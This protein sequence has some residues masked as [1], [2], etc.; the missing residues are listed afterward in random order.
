MKK[1]ITLLLSVLLIIGTLP[2]LPGYAAEST[3]ENLALGKP[4]TATSSMGGY[5]PSNV[6]DGNPGT[7]W[8]GNGWVTVDL[9]ETYRITSVV[10]YPRTDMDQVQ[11]R[12]NL[13]LELSKT[14][15]FAEQERM[16]AVDN[17]D[18]G[19]GVPI[20]VSI[21]SKTPYR[22]VR[23]GQKS[24]GH[25][26]IAEIEIFGY[27]L[28]PNALEIGED[29]SGHKHE[30]PLTLLAY[31]GLLENV[32]DNIFGV[33]HLLTRGQAARAVVKALGGNASFSGYLPFTD[34]PI[35]HKNYQDI[36]TAYHLGIVTGSDGET[37]R[38]NE[39]VSKTELLF[40]TLRAIGYDDVIPKL[41]N[42]SVSHVLNLANKLDLLKGVEYETLDEPINRADAHR[43]FYNALLAP[44][45][46]MYAMQE[47]HLVFEEDADLLRRRHNLV[48]TQGVVEETRLTNLDGDTKQG[49]HAVR[50]SGKAFTDPNGMLDAYIGRNV[51]VAT[52]QDDPERILL[53]LLTGRDE[54]VVLPA[55]RL[56]STEADINSGHI[57]ALDADGDDER[58]TL[59]DTF[60]VIKNGVV[61]PYYTT[62]DLML[63]NG[64]M[65]LLDNNR[66]GMY[67]VVFLEEYTVHYV[68][69][70]FSDE[71]ELTIVN[72]EG[73][74]FLLE[75]ESLSVTN[76]EGGT[77]SVKTITR[78]T[79]IKL[80]STPDG[81][82]CRIVLYNTP[83][84]GKLTAISDEEAAIDGT[85]YPLS[86]FYK[87]KTW[88]FEPRP[89]E[90]VK[91]FVDEAG[92]ILW[93][94]RGSEGWTIAFS[95]KTAIGTG[96]S[97]AVI[98]RMFTQDGTWKEHDVAEK[99]TL[100]GV[101]VTRED[102]A[103]KIV[104]ARGT[105]RF[106]LSMLRYKL[107][108]A[109]QIKVL[110][111]L[112]ETAAESAD[113]ISFN[114]DR[115]IGTALYTSAS[116]SF[117]SYQDQIYFAKSDTPTFVL[118][119]VNGAYTADSSY[120]SLY[121]VRTVA[122][123]AGQND[124]HSLGLQAYMLDEDGYPA[125][126]V[127]TDI[128][129]SG[130]G[131]T[132]AVISSNTAPNLLVEKVVR[133]VVD[134]TVVIKV[135]GYNVLNQTEASFY[136]EST[137]DMIETGL[138]FQEKPN[139][140]KNG[141]H[142]H[143][144]NASTLS[145]LTDEEKAIYISSVTEIGFGDLVRYEIVGGAS[146][147]TAV[148]R[149]F[150]Y[151]RTTLPTAGKSPL[152]KTWYTIGGNYPDFSFAPYR[153]QFGTL[154]NVDQKNFTLATPYSLDET[155]PKSAVSKIIY[156]DAEGAKPTLAEGTDLYAYDLAS[157]RVMLFSSGG[158]PKV[159]IVYPYQ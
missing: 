26:V 93:M 94:E 54:E 19:F 102:L 14:P 84:E 17:T 119:K 126:F 42:N 79:V 109:G 129:M 51:I 95:Q 127:K 76:A 156:C 60:H 73:E 125:C 130:G 38:P 131:Q 55:S 57:I 31:L 6:T 4:V 105:E 46:N 75:C 141:Q 101:S 92:E 64:Q 80:F 118:P 61:H 15:D 153:Y 86:W 56:N 143:Q 135:S 110:D 7:I 142:K 139:C 159:A 67:D 74:R 104:A 21:T 44:G 18:L 103:D 69:G 1:L 27:I 106:E 145:A 154:S 70:A 150:D 41:F 22:Y 37:F 59:E 47:G 149:V 96:L 33:D 63:K 133:A 116:S 120:D 24:L 144:V 82:N 111:T 157:N 152:C 39:Y 151:D 81:K 3:G 58:Y 53:A 137:K 97:P 91:A 35:T 136:V 158:A 50:I 107:N 34:V 48:L 114:K 128:N 28:D 13:I 23:V 90:D 100:D 78:D 20:E 117:W 134:D 16:I 66:N 123:A 10:L 146:T 155:Y 87:D 98:F 122:K 71:K 108:G 45:F 40:M 62:A 72:T 43:V 113:G 140:L 112:V 121:Y 138:L 49:K 65:R 8:A 148:E 11:T 88:G 89:G 52:D 36:M 5:S 77:R 85:T 83:V 25:S 132:S 124:F 29:V 68:A 115:Y 9:G 30:G 32:N 12:T 147:A 2:A 99:V